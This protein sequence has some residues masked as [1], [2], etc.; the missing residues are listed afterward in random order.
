MRLETSFFLSFFL[1]FKWTIFSYYPPPPPKKKKKSGKKI[2]AVRLAS[3]LAICW[4]GNRLFLWTARGANGQFRRTRKA[5]YIFPGRSLSLSTCGYILYL[6]M[7]PLSCLGV[8][9]VTLLTYSTRILSSSFHFSPVVC[10]STVSTK[11]IGKK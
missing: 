11:S 2:A 5:L 9:V 10:N 1:F 4:T 8:V 7:S 3:I 6:P